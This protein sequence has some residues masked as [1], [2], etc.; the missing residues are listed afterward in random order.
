MNVNHG[1][2]ERI[3]RILRMHSN[4]YEQISILK[5]GDIGAVIGLKLVSTGETLADE[6]FP[7]ALESM[8]FPEPVISVSI[9]PKTLSDQDQLSA[10]LA[11]LIKEDPTFTVKENEETGQLIISGMGELHL[12]ILVTRILE[13]YRVAANV[14]NPQV[15]YRETITL[16]KTH[17]ESYQRTLA[18]KVHEA[19]VT[20]RVEPVKRGGGN[21]FESEVDSKRLPQNL[22]EAVR[23][24]V[25]SAFPSGITLGYPCIDVKAVLT[26][27]KYNDLTVSEIALETAASLGLDKACREAGPVLLE[28]VMEVGI[29]C[30]ADK[31]GDVIS[32]LTQRGGH[33]E[34]MD[35]RPSCELI[36]AKAP[37][38]KMFGYTTVLRSLTQGRGTFSMEFS[39][40]EKKLQ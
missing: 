18:G 30:P 9:E 21:R 8:D 11:N 7:A 34:R 3:N 22:Q 27:V 19:E 37:L 15:T 31:V 5:A 12:D 32:S 38:V 16:C 39:H 33:V 20:L 40:F 25:E 13:E 2:R 10:A 4:H 35:S 36:I 1:K 14:G 6:N 17:S 26:D 23:R 28:P 24:G 29:M